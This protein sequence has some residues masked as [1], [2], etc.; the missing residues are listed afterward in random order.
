MPAHP[1]INSA[2]TSGLPRQIKVYATMRNCSLR[3]HASDAIRSQVQQHLW[4]QM[5]TSEEARLLCKAADML[6]I[7]ISHRCASIPVV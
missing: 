1:A 6:L 5:A 4:Q 7:R 3:L 2:K